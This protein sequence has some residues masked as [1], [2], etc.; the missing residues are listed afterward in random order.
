MVGSESRL[1]KELEAL[2]L[3]A[4]DKPTKQEVQQI[5]RE[6]KYNMPKLDENGE[7]DF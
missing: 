2:G 7:P 5:K 1:L 3:L 6:Y 4:P